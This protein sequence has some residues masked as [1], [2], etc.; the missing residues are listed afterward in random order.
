MTT[1]FDAV[2]ALGRKL[3]GLR[4]G[5]AD[6]GSATTCVDSDRFEVNDFWNKGTFLNITNSEWSRISGFVASTGTFTFAAITATDTNDRYAAIVPRY[7]LDALI[8]AINAVLQ[9]IEYPDEDSTSLD[10]IDNTTEYTLPVGITKQNLAQVWYRKDQDDASDKEW[11]ELTNWYVLPQSIGTQDVLVIESGID[12]GH[13]LKLRYMKYHA[14]LD[15]SSDEISPH[16]PLAR[17]LPGAAYNVIGG[18]ANFAS[19]NKWE[20]DLAQRFYNE[21][22]MAEAKHLIPKL[23]FRG[24]LIT[25]W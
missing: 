19:F 1:L 22:I 9:E 17:I 24:R 2:L 10:T 4:S 14:Y 11:F 8:E 13:D 3:Q 16:I 23:S 25:K 18:R 6:S 20:Q 21:S 12:G 7:P 15:D 5:T